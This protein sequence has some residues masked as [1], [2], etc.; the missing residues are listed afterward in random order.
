[1]YIFLYSVAVAVASLLKTK[2]IRLVPVLG[3][4]SDR[5]ILP[6]TYD[7]FYKVH[8]VHMEEGSSFI[9]D[10]LGKKNF[11][12]PGLNQHRD[13]HQIRF[14]QFFKNKNKNAIVL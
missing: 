13:L 8:D 5:L 9:S 11:C 10:L 12:K 4:P 3:I 2:S 6:K 14:L 1:M 7:D